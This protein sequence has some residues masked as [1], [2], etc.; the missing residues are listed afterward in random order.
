MAMNSNYRMVH[1]RRRYWQHRADMGH[2]PQGTES[3]VE[4]ITGQPLEGLG[5]WLLHNANDN[6]VTDS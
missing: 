4:Y 6:R 2:V 5:A 3:R 1:L